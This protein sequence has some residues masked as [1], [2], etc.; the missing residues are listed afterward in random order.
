ML[1]AQKMVPKREFIG[2]EKIL[3]DHTWLKYRISF[4]ASDGAIVLAITVAVPGIPTC[5]E[6]L[7]A[8]NRSRGDWRGKCG[9]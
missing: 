3:S 9:Y 2:Y 1:A 8:S 7:G 6:S 5:G 4:H